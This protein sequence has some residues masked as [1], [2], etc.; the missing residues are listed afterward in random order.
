M[1][2]PEQ[3]RWKKA[4]A[5]AAAKLVDEGM[6]VG[7]GTGSTAAFLVSALGR[8]IAE[9]NLR[10]LGIPTSKQTAAH[11]QS[12]NIPL[13]TFAE[14]G[15]IDLT[16]DGADEI[17][18]RTLGLIKGHG[19]ALLREKIVAAASRRMIVVADESKIV[20]RLG[21]RESVPVEVVPFG[22]QVTLRRLE[23]LGASATLRPCSDNQTFVTDGGNYII[24][25]KFDAIA[26]PKELANHLDHIVG[27]IENGLFLGLASEAIIGGRDG[28]RILRRTIDN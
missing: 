13:T 18:P 23:K 26:N 9:E 1:N 25:C 22:W 28:I 19:G 27:A 21:A 6:V 4:A 14:H 10:I 17:E 16:I 15:H 5:E 20:E 3:D 12:L 11:A 8:R 24:D 7:L 2:L